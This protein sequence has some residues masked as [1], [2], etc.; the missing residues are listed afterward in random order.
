MRLALLSGWTLREIAD[1]VRIGLSTL[2]R[3]VGEKR[4]AGAPGKAPVDVHA[5]L[6]RL[7]RGNAAL[8]QERDIPK[9]G[10]HR[11]AIGLGVNGYALFA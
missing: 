4:D 6:E 8:K 3:R 7:W 2:T 11:C 1:D 10:P 9:T 5:E